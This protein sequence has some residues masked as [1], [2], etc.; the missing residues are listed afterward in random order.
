MTTHEPRATTDQRSASDR[1]DVGNLRRDSSRWS[2]V[3][4][5]SLLVAATQALLVN[6]APVTGAAADHFGVSIAAVGWLSQVYPLIYVVL[7]IPAGLL[8]DRFFRPA[9][10][11]GTVL[12][13]AGAFLRLVSDEFTW[14]LIGQVVAAVGQPL[15]LNA[16]A[17][18]ALGYLAERDRASGIAV[19]SA[20]TFAGMVL[21]YMLG[22]FLPGQSHIRTL[23]L[24]TAVIALTAGC[25]LLGTLRVI[26]P[27]S[28]FEDTPR[29]GGVRA[30]Q[31]AFANRSL[32]RLC[33]GAV[34]PMGTFM[35]LVTFAQPL[36][37]PSGVSESTA[38]LI[39]AFTMVA[40][41]IGC[42]VIPAWAD[43]RGR[44]I[45]FLGGSILF[46]AAACLP[47][48]LI[49]S[50][51]VACFALLGIGFVLLPALPIVLTLAERHAPEAGNTA[52][53]TIW[54]AGNLGGVLLSTAVG[55]LA[56]HPAAAFITLAAATLLALPALSWYQRLQRHAPRAA[57][58]PSDPGIQAATRVTS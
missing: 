30:F 5:F 51:A 4:A 57:H 58:A 1:D 45:R 9:L 39:L 28:G 11:A 46:T 32:R 22:A 3:A 50:T 29:T 2:I 23:T 19:A 7:A 27:L 52:A 24:V 10:I 6:Y 26:K 54:M 20:A 40:G 33:V 43:R 31:A 36:L 42:A 37:E 13:V 21:G 17:G 56:T 55:L 12:T 41:V 49:P 53:G 44:E 15:V 48:A 14:A 25:C 35:A 34:I 18:L 8:L 16:I 47:L 38:G